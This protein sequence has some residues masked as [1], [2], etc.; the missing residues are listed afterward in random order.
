MISYNGKGGL[1]TLAVGLD[2][3]C[4]SCDSCLRNDVVLIRA[5]VE[6]HPELLQYT[7]LH[8]FHCLSN[9]EP[10]TYFLIGLEGK[11]VRYSTYEDF[12]MAQRLMAAA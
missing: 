12:R 9:G 4:S 8:V 1:D 6:K 3:S 7:S 2:K 11:P 5:Y 10:K